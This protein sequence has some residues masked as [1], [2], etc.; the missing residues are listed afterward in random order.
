MM[1]NFFLCTA[2]RAKDYFFYPAANPLLKEPEEIWRLRNDYTLVFALVS[3]NGEVTFS[4]GPLTSERKDRQGRRCV[5]SFVVQSSVPDDK[6]QMGRI[7]AAMLKSPEMQV[8]FAEEF[9]TQIVRNVIAGGEWDGQLPKIDAKALPVSNASFAIDQQLYPA[10][11]PDA[12]ECAAKIATLIESGRDF[13]VGCCSPDRSVDD[14]V[15]K[16]QE[17]FRFDWKNTFIAVFSPAAVSKT[18]LQ[19]SKAQ[20]DVQR[21]PQVA[22]YILG[23]I[24]VFILL[25]IML[26]VFGRYEH[27]T[28]P[29]AS[30]LQKEKNNTELKK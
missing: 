1:N 30:S 11:S 28:H 19:C 23:G 8:K 24:V 4:A 2:T 27:D 9:E 12:E 29:S 22:R 10:N 5:N 20:H 3:H 7:F 14:V 13:A 26:V 21:N 6:H 16:L 25:M 15:Q 18:P 17:M